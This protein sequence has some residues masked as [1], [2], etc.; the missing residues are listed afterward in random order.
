MRLKQR[1]G[2]F[3][4]RELLH[5]DYLRE[6]GDHRVYRVT[7]RKITTPEAARELASEAG[8]E[9]ADVS[10]A[11]LKDRQGITI[12]HMSVPGGREVRLRAQEVLIEPVG[13]ADEALES[14]FSRGNA[15]EITARALRSADVARLRKNVAV[16]REHGLVNYFDE[17]RFGNLKHDQGW[18]ALELMRGDHGG[19]LKRLLTATGPFGD[20]RE[21]RLKH[22]LAENWGDWRACRDI[23]G[24]LGAHHS[25]FE[26][27]A[28]NDGDFAGAFRFVSSRV[29]LIHLYAWQSHVWNRAVAEVVRAAVPMEQ[30]VVLD[31]IEG[32]LVTYSGAPPAGLNFERDFPLPGEALEGVTEPADLDALEDVLAREQL[33]PDQFRITG[34]PGFQLKGEPRRLLVRPRHLRVRPAAAD[35]LNPG[36]QHIRVRFELPRGSYATL[37]VR[38]LLSTALRGAEERAQE[39][40]SHAAN[41]PARGGGARRS[42]GPRVGERDREPRTGDSRERDR[43]RRAGG[44]GDRDRGPRSG[45]YG[46][47]D[48]GQRSGGYGDRDRGPRSGGYRDRDRGQRSGGYGDRD[49]GP[50]SGG[51]GDRDRGQ[52]SGGYGDRDRGP[53]S[54]GYRD[55]DRGQRSGGDRDRGPRSGGHGDRD[56]GQRSGGYGDRD[57]GPRSGGHGDRDRG[58]RSGGY[59]DRDRGR[60]SGGYGDRDRGQRSGSYG[61]RDRGS[62]SGSYGDRDR[63]QRSGGYRGRDNDRRSGGNRGRDQQRGSGGFRPRG[64]DDRRRGPDRDRPERGAPRSTPFGGARKKHEERKEDSE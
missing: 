63:G 1:A 19:A 51:Y 15:F 29:R 48:R 22:A 43:G 13:F 41:R 12:Q 61:D 14:R 18:I 53:R 44:Y 25:V 60:R 40:K 6:S 31:S 8:I 32:P 58:P 37:V 20:A 26:H 24:K 10:Y 16:V 9:P 59:G 7:K 46:D 35:T 11:G 54:G 38:R 4:V 27:L 50:R 30:R 34:V 3:R 21:G 64:D 56:R 49:R 2:D 39:R 52:R 5:E 47:R 33:V 17:Q 55:R 36:C 62:R 57:R 42:H 28:K 45:S 23:A